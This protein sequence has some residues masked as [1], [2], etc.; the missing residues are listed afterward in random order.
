MNTNVTRIVLGAAALLALAPGVP[1]D[2]QT[3]RVMRTAAGIQLVAADG[4]ITPVPVH[5]QNGAVLVFNCDASATPAIDCATLTVALLDPATSV[6]ETLTPVSP[7]AAQAQILVAAGKSGDL[8]VRL[9]SV[10]AVP[11]IPLGAGGV[12]GA[13]GMEVEAVERREVACADAAGLKGAYD[14]RRN[15]AAFVVTTDGFVIDRP[16]QPVDENDIVDIHVVGNPDVLRTVKVE[17]TSTIRGVGRVR[18]L[19]ETE[20]GTIRRQ[21]LAT[22]CG[23]ASSPV[24][25]FE[26]GEGVVTITSTANGQRQTGRVSLRVNPLYNGAFSFGPVLSRLEDLSYGMLPDSTIT[27][28]EVGE[29]HGEY[30]LTYT[31]FVWGP[32]DVEKS[33]IGLENFNPMIGISLQKPL[34]SVFLGGAFDLLHGDLFIV[35]GAHGGQVTR[36]NPDARLA[37]G[38]KLPARYTS[39]PTREEWRWEWFYGVTVDLRAAVKLF[40]SVLTGGTK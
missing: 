14:R 25:D 8:T 39:V 35:A 24:T 18:F 40:G 5:P 10:S 2:A 27:E 34:E 3:Y 6:P 29:P 38:D 26:P 36:L 12:G 13:G 1:A 15:R 21:A 28:T 32:R 33:T 19:G 17:R 11:A 9:G 4:Q 31:H 7:T 20:A 23:Y 22:D 16:S 30:L 37:A